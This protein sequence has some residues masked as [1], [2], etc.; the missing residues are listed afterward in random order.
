MITRKQD[1]IFGVPH[2]QMI[3]CV[4]RGE[5]CDP[6][7]IAHTNSLRIVNHDC[8]ARSFHP[9]H[10]FDATVGDSGANAVAECLEAREGCFH[11]GLVGVADCIEDG[12]GFNC[13]GRI[14]RLKRCFIEIKKISPLAE[15]R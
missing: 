14:K 4:A 6:I 13:V 11:I 15:H 12:C 2:A 5:D 8:G 10:L 3:V 7:A 9:R 1:A